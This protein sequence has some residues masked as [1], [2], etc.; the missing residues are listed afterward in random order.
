MTITATNATLDTDTDKSCKVNVNIFSDSME[1]YNGT[2][3]D[4]TSIGPLKFDCYDVVTA[5]TNAN[6]T[7]QLTF[8]TKNGSSMASWMS[9]DSSAGN[10]SISIPSEISSDNFTITNT[11]TGVLGNNFTLATDLTINI[12]EAQVV[13]NNSNTNTNTNTNDDDH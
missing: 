4:T 8:A 1:T 6:F 3:N 11:Y 7:N 2:V 5:A 12:V 10:V 13:P 9:F